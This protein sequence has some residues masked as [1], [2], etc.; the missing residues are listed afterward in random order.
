VKAG[1]AGSSPAPEAIQLNTP[2]LT[3][4]TDPAELAQI[5]VDFDM[6]SAGPIYRVSG[7]R[8]SM[9]P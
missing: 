1:G 6:V 9:N 7:A 8:A 4:V 3:E 2:V 5:R